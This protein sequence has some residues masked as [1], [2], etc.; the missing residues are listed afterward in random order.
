[1]FEQ[2]KLYISNKWEKLYPL[3]FSSM[4]CLLLYFFKDNEI[5]D[6]CYYK[7]F[8]K[9]FIS[10]LVTAESIVFGFLLTTM[11]T[12][13]QLNNSAIKNLIDTNRFP[14]LIQEDSGNIFFFICYLNLCVF[15]NIRN[16][17]TLLQYICCNMDICYE[18]GHIPKL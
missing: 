7:C 14:E 13:M 8:D 12:L 15:I 6:K 3:L 2:I 16:S 11:V 10:A 4:I 5:I 17:N 18:Y 1:M 9:T